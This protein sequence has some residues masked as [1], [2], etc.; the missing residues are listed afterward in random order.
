MGNLKKYNLFF[1]I[2]RA[3]AGLGASE[4]VLFIK[5]KF[6]VDLSEQESVDFELFSKKDFLI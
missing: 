6:L 5:Q 3:F 1:Q 2:C 4:A